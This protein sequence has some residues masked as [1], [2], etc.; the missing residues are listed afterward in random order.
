MKNKDERIKELEREGRELKFLLFALT[1][2]F[3][4]IIIGVFLAFLYG[5]GEGSIKSLEQQLKSCQDVPYE[6]TYDY[7]FK[8]VDN[9]PNHI[10]R[11]D[12]YGESYYTVPVE[13]SCGVDDFVMIQQLCKEDSA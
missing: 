5:N 2:F 8:R 9:Y 1:M 7:L 13:T 10:I 3:V 4:I 12:Y 6:Q 11:T